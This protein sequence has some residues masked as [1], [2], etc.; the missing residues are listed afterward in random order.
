MKTFN[1]TARSDAGGQVAGVAEANNRD[2]A[3][4]QLRDSGLIV[5]RISE[6]GGASRDIDL[7]LGARKAKEK[8]LAIVC[9]QF[10][11][12]LQAGLPI[13][14][15]LQLIADQTEDKTLKQVLYDAADDVAA[16]YSLA[17]SLEKHGDGLPTTFVE[18][19]RAG[20]ESG[21]LETVFR[22]LKDYY[23]KTSRTKAKVK[24]AMV[25]PT[26]VMVIAV[27][28]V[29][30]IMIFAVP[31]FRST[32][33]SMGTDLPAVTQFVIDSSDFWVHW[34]WLVL[35]II[36]IASIGVNVG[37][38]SSDA[39]RLAWSKLGVMLPF[40]NIRTPV[41]GRINL[42]NSAS[43]YAGTMSVMMSAG[44]PIVKAVGVTARSMNNYF[45]GHSLESTMPELE[46][47]R[48]LASCLQREATLPNLAIE[49]TAVGEQTGSLESTMEVIAEYYDN[50]VE[51]ATGRA[52]SVLEPII[53]VVL[54]VIVFVLLLSVYLPMFTM[55][56]GITA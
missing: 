29:A 37:K 21:S 55:Y 25:Y 44:L 41:I 38:R 17:D 39:F 9:N 2:E 3:V 52:M 4:R 7:K 45:M 14:R 50:E 11:I 26:F 15:T 10:A 20:E 1:Y 16:G 30:I 24:S 13:V 42:M 46:A 18:S 34:W 31:V 35:M 54:A 32:F 5:E 19:I 12:L 33:D 6:I 36:I 49:M 28:V 8:S 43:E 22:R 27:L 23:E 47:G 56:G 51:T 40:G 53:I 48:P